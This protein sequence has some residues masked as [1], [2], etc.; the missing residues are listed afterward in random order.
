MSTFTVTT[1]ADTIDATDGKTSLREAVASANATVGY[2][3]I[4]FDASLNGGLIRLGSVLTITGDLIIDADPDPGYIGSGITKIATTITITGDKNGDDIRIGTTQITD[5]TASQG[6]G[7][8]SDNVQLFSATGASLTFDG[9][10]LTG[11]SALNGGAVQSQ[12]VSLYDTVVSGNHAAVNGGGVHAGHADA[13]MSELSN[14]SAIGLGGGLFSNSLIA[15]DS[16]FDNN[17]ATTGGGVYSIIA[18][19]SQSTVSNNSANDAAGLYIEQTSSLRFSTVSG[20]NAKG[21]GGGILV[22]T[23]IDIENSTITGNSAAT[24]GGIF[25]TNAFTELNLANSI[26]LGNSAAIATEVHAIPHTLSA[27]IVSGLYSA[28]GAQ[29]SNAKVQ[30]YGLNIVGVGADADGSDGVISAASVAAV[31]ESIDPTN[32]GGNLADNGGRVQSVALNGSIANPALD[33]ARDEFYAHYYEFL[34]QDGGIYWY[35]TFDVATVPN[36]TAVA[37]DIG[38]SEFSP[39]AREDRGLV[40]STLSSRTN[41]FDDQTSL[42]EALSYAS[43]IGGGVITFDPMLSGGLIRLS[44]AYSLDIY[45]PIT[46]NG[47]IDGDG[48]ADITISGDTKGDDALVAGSNI[49]DMAASIAN[50]SFANNVPIFSGHGS[51]ELTL[52]GLILT[53]GV[54]DFGGAVATYWDVTISNSTIS[55]NHAFYKGG[56]VYADNYF[57]TAKVTVTNS[58]IAD[59]SANEGGGI[60]SIAS[61][62]IGNSTLSGNSASRGGGVFAATAAISSTTV[63]GNSASVSGGGISTTGGTTL[64]NSIVLGNKAP[65]SAEVFGTTIMTGGNI[66]G[67]NVFKNA[68]DIGNTTASAIFASIDANGGGLLADYGGGV[69]TIA[70]KNDSTNPAIDAASSAAPATDQSG[71]TRFDWAST[72]NS[73]GSPVDLGASEVQNSAPTIGPDITLTVEEDGASAPFRIVYDDINWNSTGL[74]IDFMPGTY[75]AVLADRGSNPGPGI[76]YTFTPEANANGQMSIKFIAIDDLGARAEQLVTVNIIP[77]DDDPTAISLTATQTTL[78]ENASTLTAIKVADI[79]VTDIDGGPNILVN[80]VGLD[81]SLFEIIGDSV[82]LKAGTVIDFESQSSYSVAA[83]VVNAVVGSIPYATSSTYTLN[84][85]DS[86]EAPT[87]VALA[88]T[89]MSLAEGTSTASRI[90]VADIAVTDDAIG[91][92]TL[93]LTGADASSFEIIGTELFLKAGVALDFETKPSSPLLCK[94]MT[95]P[96]DQHPTPSARLSSSA[97]AI[98]HP[99][100]STDPPH[101]TSSPAALIST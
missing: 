24:G 36:S 20:N 23:N 15:A 41:A 77:V 89:I 68:S 96:L 8:H 43:E 75:G 79:S 95:Q 56:G 47:D 5:V 74:F 51:S 97:C 78:A 80:L 48:H 37:A 16:T 13:H 17:D 71:A 98:F 73:N 2:D 93:S 44:S 27:P 50:G 4:T 76:L 66:L 28:P 82:F 26:V 34:E 59:N 42:V 25:A 69:W 61:A 21:N 83:H 62:S 19:L 45:W 18:R 84:I 9:L 14:N 29:T 88:N 91:T 86:N 10:T 58:T 39:R 85:T 55:G 31:F 60:Y 30:Y 94:W 52:N 64:T 92:N 70:L 53:G 87:A 100:S 40:V 49:T 35:P 3:T 57:S 1:L 63:S 101:P 67:T 90:K 72:T 22:K 32:G 54:S 46:I 33:S 11:G 81:A 7:T 6:A 12:Y 99:K 38:A 65:A